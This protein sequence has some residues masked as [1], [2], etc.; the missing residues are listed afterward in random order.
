MAADLFEHFDL[1]RGVPAV[2]A[3]DF[4][5][6]FDE[7]FAGETIGDDSNASVE[8][9]AVFVS[10]ES[11]FHDPAIGA[12]GVVSGTFDRIRGHFA[13]GN[14]GEWRSVRVNQVVMEQ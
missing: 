8:T 4:Q 9:A 5:V 2:D 12:L 11:L 6:L 7:G 10:S 3:F 14:K 1:P 13:K